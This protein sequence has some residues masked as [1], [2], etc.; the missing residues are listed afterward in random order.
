MATLL[1][2]LP[3]LILLCGHLNFAQYYVKV[4]KVQLLDIP[5]QS[6]KHRWITQNPIAN[7]T[8][9]GEILRVFPF[10]SRIKSIATIIQ[11]SS[12]GSGQCATSRK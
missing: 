8:L 11:H 6:D 9:T 12:R 7:V 1:H 5:H 10:T 4:I 2:P 3:L